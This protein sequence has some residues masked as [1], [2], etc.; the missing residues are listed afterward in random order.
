V[1]DVSGLPADTEQRVR[2]ALP[3][4]RGP[5]AGVESDSASL[6]E[7]WLG[8]ESR[9]HRPSRLAERRPLISENLGRKRYVIPFRF[10][11]RSTAL[12]ALFAVSFANAET[13][14]SFVLTGTSENFG[15]YFPSY[16]ANGYFSTMTSLRGPSPT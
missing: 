7:S 5:T 10:A 14:P 3:A 11:L 12:A 9:H 2:L 1:I 13:D 16:L 8:V 4:S 15:S 6:A